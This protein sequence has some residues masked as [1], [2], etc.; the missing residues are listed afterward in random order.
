VLGAVVSAQYK[1]TLEENAATLPPPQRA[2]VLRYQ[3]EVLADGRA[4]PPAVRAAIEDAS[5]SAYRLGLG[6]GG[7]LVV[8][9]GVI[10][11]VGIV[12]PRRAERECAEEHSHGP[13]RLQQP[14]IETRDLPVVALPARQP[15]ATA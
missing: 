13:A 1:S 5:V 14:C 2:A 15:R 8:L 10:S 11:L 4:Q 12:N 3:D 9:G 6:V 7:G